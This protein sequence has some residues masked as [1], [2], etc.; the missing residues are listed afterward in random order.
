MIA[1]PNGCTCSELTVTPKDWKTCKAPAMA[2]N[3]HIQYYFYYTALKQRKFVLVKGMNRLKTLNE[4]R[5]ATSQLI[6][7]ELYQLKEKGYNPITGKFLIEKACG[8]DPKT[9][10]IDAL[11]KAYDL[12]KLEGTTLQD[13]SSSINFFEIAAKKMGIDRMEIQ[14]VKRRHLRQMLE[15]FEELKKSWSAYSFNNCRAYLMML[16]KKLLEQDAVE[17]NPVKD[18][19]K[20]MIIQ[21]IKRV[22]NSKERL[23]IDKHLKEVDPDYRRFIHIFFHSGSRKTEMV[24]LKV[25]DVDLKKQVFKLLIKKGSQQREVLRPIKNIAL[26]FGKSNWKMPVLVIMFSV[27]ILSQGKRKLLPKG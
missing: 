14:S 4:R 24:R 12:L 25:A 3:W 16:Y 11:R 21:R 2:R 13:I 10:F 7:N 22:L 8:I 9:G 26:D 5:E 19:P 20:Q 6:E 18:I 15:M 23:N 1:L 17:I 27:L